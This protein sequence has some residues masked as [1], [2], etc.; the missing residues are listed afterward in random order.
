MLKI[1][2]IKKAQKGMALFKNYLTVKN[3]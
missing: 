1:P 3:T 2:T